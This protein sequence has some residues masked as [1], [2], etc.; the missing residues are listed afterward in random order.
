MKAISDFEKKLKSL[1]KAESVTPE[2]MLAAKKLGFS[3]KQIARCLQTT[4]LVMRS[5]RLS[6]NIVPFVKQIDTVSAEFPCTNNYLYMTYNAVEDDVPRVE[7][8]PEASKSIMVLG[9]GP[10]SIGSS[11]EFGIFF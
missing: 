1:A 11:V 5:I 4:E 6:F 8:S 2:I 7:K 3:D 10:Y 9:S